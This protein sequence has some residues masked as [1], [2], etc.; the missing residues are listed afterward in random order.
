MTQALTSDDKLTLE[1]IIDSSSLEQ[2]L[3][4][5]GDICREKAGH[6]RASYSDKATAL[7]WARQ[8]LGTNRRAIRLS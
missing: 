7:T 3:E 8:R 6:I 5:L 2:V 4:N 1:K